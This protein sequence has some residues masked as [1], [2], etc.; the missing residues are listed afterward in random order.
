[1]IA[2][3]FGPKLYSHKKKYA[4]ELNSKYDKTLKI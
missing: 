1:M 3:Q 4:I 2:K